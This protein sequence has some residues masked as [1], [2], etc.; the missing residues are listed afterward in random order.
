[1][2]PIMARARRSDRACAS[3]HS[4]TPPDASVIPEGAFIVVCSPPLPAFPARLRSMAGC[5][6]LGNEQPDSYLLGCFPRVRLNC[7]LIG[8]SEVHTSEL[9]SLMRISYAVFWFIKH[10]YNAC[11]CLKQS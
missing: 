4:T 7:I 1:M 8:T 5:T 3:W 2:R 6:L 11:L 9:Q 10:I